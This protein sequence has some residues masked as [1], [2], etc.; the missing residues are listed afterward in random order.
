MSVIATVAV[1]ATAFPLGAALESDPDATVSVETT[2]PTSAE[3]IPYLW[4]PTTASVVDALEECSSVESAAVIDEVDDHALVKLEWRD[5][6]NGVLESIRDADAIVLSAV[7]TVDRW[8]FRLRFPS[9][10]HLSAFYAA[11]VERE[12][13]VELEQLHETV[14]PNSERRYGLTGPQRDLVVAAHEVGYFDVPR[15][16]TLVELGDRLGISDSA[17]SQRLRR[18]L[19]ALIDSTLAV[20]LDGGTDWTG[21]PTDLE[22]VATG[23][24]ADGSRSR[25][26]PD[27]TT[28]SNSDGDSSTSSGSESD[29]DP[30]DASASG[31]SAE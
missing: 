20:G 1:P 10:E 9:Y 8:T 29:S 27:P 11:C 26:N 18:G 6:V 25:A 31:D 14:A 16:T 23:D 7:G 24:S 19:S 30:A 17:V 15:R 4:V 13:A 5:D 22:S 12:I 3:V 28:N 2:V 21:R